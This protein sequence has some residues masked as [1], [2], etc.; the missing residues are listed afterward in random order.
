MEFAEQFCLRLYKHKEPIHHYLKY[1]NRLYIDKRAHII[2]PM[3]S[4]YLPITNS[5]EGLPG[6][7]KAKS[8]NATEYSWFS[9]G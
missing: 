4:V 2:R 5:V 7:K 3:K 1:I 9:H 6:K 8:R